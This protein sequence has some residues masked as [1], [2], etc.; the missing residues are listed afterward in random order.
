MGSWI[1]LCST[2][3]DKRMHLNTYLLTRHYFL[4]SQGLPATLPFDYAEYVDRCTAALLVKLVQV[5]W[6]T[7]L[8]ILTFA[9]MSIACS[10]IVDSVHGTDRHMT[11]EHM[12]SNTAAVNLNY[13]WAMFFLGWSLYL[14]NGTCR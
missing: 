12:W 9:A 11:M 3:L 13:F 10:L 14:T 5:G 6:R 1:T 8:G 7:W 4:L 2:D